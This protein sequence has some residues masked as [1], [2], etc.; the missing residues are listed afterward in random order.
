MEFV[1]VRLVRW[2]VLA[3]LNYGKRFP[4]IGKLGMAELKLCAI[5]LDLW[6]L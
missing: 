2:V 3:S 1:L 5:N 6:A 4:E